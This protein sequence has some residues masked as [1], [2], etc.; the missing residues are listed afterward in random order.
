MLRQK[1]RPKKRILNVG[2]GEDMYG[3]DRLDMKKTKAT[4]KVCDIGKGLP[5]Q[6]NTFDEIRAYFI[7][8]HLRNV[9]FF[10]DECYRILKRGG[11]LDLQTDNA[12]YLPFYINYEHNKALDGKGYLRHP[13]DHHYS[14]FVFSHLKYFLK[15]FSKIQFSYVRI[16]RRVWKNIILHCLPFHLGYSEIRAIAIK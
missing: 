10:I 5:Y 4:T 14:L 13:N 7:L 1:S 16:K 6:D 8:E 3:T 9:G 12:G 2:C 15:D 11:L